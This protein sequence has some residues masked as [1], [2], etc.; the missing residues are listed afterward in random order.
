VA[1]RIPIQPV[2]SGLAFTSRKQMVD[3]S[4]RF[5]GHV[6]SIA[7]G[8]FPHFLAIQKAKE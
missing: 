2:A 7:T 3:P 6:S 4:L 8:G 1:G 5:T